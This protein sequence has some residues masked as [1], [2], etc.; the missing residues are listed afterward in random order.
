MSVFGSP[1]K[2]GDDV[3]NEEGASLLVICELIPLA[4]YSVY[5]ELMLRQMTG[6][7]KSCGSGCTRVLFD[8]ARFAPDL[9]LTLNRIISCDDNGGF[10]LCEVTLH[11]VDTVRLHHP[12]QKVTC[13]T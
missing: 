12:G 5:A 6:I 11:H 2:A 10:I 1:N 3:M 13:F 9:L 4:P 7:S 8:L